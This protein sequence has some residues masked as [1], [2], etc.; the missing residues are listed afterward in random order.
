L[1]NNNN[2][3]VAERVGRRYEEVFGRVVSLV[4][5]GADAGDGDMGSKGVTSRAAATAPARLSQLVHALLVSDSNEEHSAALRGM[6]LD[7]LCVTSPA[8]NTTTTFIFQPFCF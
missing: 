6:L 3:A 2:N 7:W 1:C 5:S 8:A 4:V